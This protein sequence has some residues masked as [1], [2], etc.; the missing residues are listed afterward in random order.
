[1]KPTA[2]RPLLNTQ[3]SIPTTGSTAN[4]KTNML[5]SSTPSKTIPMTPSHSS[6]SSTSNHIATT[7]AGNFA[8]VAASHSNSQAIHS[9]S[10]KTSSKTLLFFML[11]YRTILYD[12]VIS[13]LAADIVVKKQSRRSTAIFLNGLLYKHQFYS[14]QQR[15]W[16]FVIVILIVCINC[17]NQC[18]TDGRAA[19]Q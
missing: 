19:A 16:H 6:P 5:S 1:M 4:I 8:T 11:Q 3:A 13:A 7:N 12:R 15:E 2:V 17:Y 10:N 14:S 18:A 9:T